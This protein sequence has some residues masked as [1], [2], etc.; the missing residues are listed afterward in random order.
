MKICMAGQGAFGVKHLEAI[1]RIPGIEVVTLAGGSADSTREVAEKF[2]VGAAAPAQKRKLSFAE[3]HALK[4][5]PVRMEKL[6]AELRRLELVL[7]QPDLYRKDPATFASTTMA[8]ATA[9][10]ELTEVEEQW[11]AAELRREEVEGQ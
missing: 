7:G 9:R 2:S 5:L 6:T 11:L 8:L 10:S 4:T 3:Q 1:R